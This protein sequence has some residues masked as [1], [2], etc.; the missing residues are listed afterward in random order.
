V[1]QRSKQ[2]TILYI[3][4]VLA[5]VSFNNKTGFSQFSADVWCFGDSALI[6]FSNGNPST[7]SSNMDNI[8]SSCTIG[9]SQHPLLLY[10]ENYYY[11]TW[12]NGS[13]NN[14]AIRN[15]FGNVI[16]R[17]DSLEGFGGKND[18][19]FLPVPGNDSVVFLFHKSISLSI[20]SPGLYYSTVDFKFNGYAGRCLSKN[21]II[22]CN[23]NLFQ[24]GLV[25]IKHGNG[26]DWWIIVRNWFDGSSFTTTFNKLLI[27]KNQIIGP[28]LQ[29][30]GQPSETDLTTLV[31]SNDGSKIVNVAY[32]LV[33][34]F[35]FDRCNGILTNPQIVCNSSTMNFWGACF[36]PNNR[37]L[38]LANITSNQLDSVFIYQI[39]LSSPNPFASK[40]IIY[41]DY[42]NAG[43]GHLKLAPDGKIYVGAMDA[44]GWRYLDSCRT[45]YNE[46]LSVINSPD[47]FG[48]GCQFTPFSFFLGGRRTYWSLP[49]N[50][51]YTLGV[52]SNSVCDSLTN[53]LSAPE[54]YQP[55]IYPNPAVN[56]LNVVFREPA[57]RTLLIYNTLGKLVYSGNSYD[58]S[59]LIDISDFPPGVY[60]LTHKSFKLRFIISR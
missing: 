59:V 44:C 58:K 57:D 1:T 52:L 43:F 16:L 50:P 13:D 11:N 60:I 33:E 42:I 32:G 20:P 4:F 49:N 45:Q 35:D 39:D 5:I 31:C 51:N 22:N 38:Y 8:G 55:A 30:I 7:T 23:D 36:S 6:D 25:A 9:N 37:F 18:L 29:D 41:A 34:V 26:R 14:T 19:I 48:L 54:P 53:Y 21:S 46:N 10:A 47:S 17:G 56:S 2:K 27:T 40:I 24:D 15:Q 28:D 3:I 12:I